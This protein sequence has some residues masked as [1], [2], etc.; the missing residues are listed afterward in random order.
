MLF[1]ETSVSKSDFETKSGTYQPTGDEGFV[2]RGIAFWMKSARIS[3]PKS[4]FVYEIEAKSG[5]RIR[6]ENPGDEFFLDE[7]FVHEI[8]P[9]VS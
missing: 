4:E 7:G 8:P 5:F 6:M 1:D 3:S 9:R 2:H